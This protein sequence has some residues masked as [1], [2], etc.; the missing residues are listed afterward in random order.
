MEAKVKSP[1]GHAWHDKLSFPLA[2]L[3]KCQVM[4]SICKAPALGA[5]GHEQPAYR[6]GHA[7]GSTLQHICRLS[8]CCP[9]RWL[10]S[11]REH[12]DR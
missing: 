9:L 12:S 3:R 6:P 1:Y 4:R 10:D 11:G 7:A 8:G 5:S 2:C